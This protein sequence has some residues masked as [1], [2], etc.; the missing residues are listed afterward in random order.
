MFTGRDRKFR[1]VNAKY[2]NNNKNVDGETFHSVPQLVMIYQVDEFN[3]VQEF[4]EIA[5]SAD[6][7]SLHL[8]KKLGCR[9]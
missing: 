6:I 1:K 2:R 5:Y 3:L 7:Y 4:D 9:F 8:A